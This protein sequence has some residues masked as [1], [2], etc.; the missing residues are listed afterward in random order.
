MMLAN[1][2]AETNLKVPFQIHQEWEG[3]GLQDSL[4]V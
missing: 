3:D 2:F 1:I 4:L